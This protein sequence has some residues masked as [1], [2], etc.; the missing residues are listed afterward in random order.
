VALYEPVGLAGIV[1][2]TAASSAAMTL[3]QLHSLRRELH[4]RLE[5]RQTLVAVAQMSAASALLG[6]VAYGVWYALDRGLGS[7]LP[8]QLV[9][10]GAGLAA[11]ALAYGLTVHLLRIPE[12]R[13]IEQLVAGRLFRR[14]KR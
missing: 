9:S 5:G 1:V 10:V 13:Q 8:A 2:G 11:G 3:A 7:G 14:A 6:A 4:G 12:A